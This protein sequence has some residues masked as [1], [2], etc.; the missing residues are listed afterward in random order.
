[1]AV[2]S[3][4][5]DRLAPIAR[6]RKPQTASYVTNVRPR[7]A[8]PEQLLEVARAY[9]GAIEN[10]VHRVRDGKPREDACRVRKGN[11]PGALAAF[12][13]LALWMLRMLGHKNIARAMEELSRRQARALAVR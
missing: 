8:G 4:V 11:L 12:N 7:N 10:G 13:S 3:Q 5:G 6:Y 9:F 2:A 1:M